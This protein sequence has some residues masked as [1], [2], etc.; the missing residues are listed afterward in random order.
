[1]EYN[2]EDAYKEYPIE[3]GIAV[4]DDGSMLMTRSIMDPLPAFMK[5]ADMIFTDSP[6]NQG[7]LRSF[8]TKAEIAPDYGYDFLRFG[9]RLFD[10]IWEIDPKVC[11]LEIGKENLDVW[12]I[13]MKKIFKHVTFF[14]STY[15]HDPQKLCYIVRGARKVY[16]GRK[17]DGMDEEDIISAVCSEEEYE[18]A[19]DLCTGRGLV[20]CAAFAAGKKF[21]GTELNHKRLSVCLKRLSGLGA[22]YRVET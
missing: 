5:K 8:Y 22:S 4:F 7:N 21:V 19:G 1:M 3:N 15:Y 14:N 6:W 10:C 17:Y 13:Q 9:D 12:L 18:V 11:Y 20:P 16:R 2:Y